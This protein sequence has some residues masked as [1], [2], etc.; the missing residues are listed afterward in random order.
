MIHVYVV[1]IYD[2]DK[3]KSIER[4]DINLH[5]YS[6]ELFQQWGA[7]YTAAV[8]RIHKQKREILLTYKH[9]P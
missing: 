3:N 5:F 7:D 1:F 2:P 9:Q 4:H 6:V 8:C